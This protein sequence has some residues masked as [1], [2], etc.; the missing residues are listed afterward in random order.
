MSGE[1]EFSLRSV[2]MAA[3]VPSTLYG[4]SQG[5]VL[6]VIALSALD[7]GASSAVAALIASLL[8]TGAIVTNIPSGILATRVGENRAMLVASAVTIL[9]LL[10]CLVPVHSQPAGLLLLGLAILLL[11][12]ASSVFNLARQAYLTEAVP[13]RL[14]ARALS[15]L[16]GMSRI[17]VFLGPFLS[18]VAIHRWGLPGAYVVSLVAMVA[19]A[20]IIARIPDLEAGEQR[21]K[22]AAEVTTRV[23]LRD[24]RRVFLTLGLGIVLLCAV[25]QTRQ[26]VIPL[27][28]AH[29]GLSSA[30]SSVIY[31][32]AGG[33]DVVTFYPAGR[34]MDRQGRRWVA[35]P[36]VLLLAASFVAMTWSHG[37]VT[38]ALA[39]CVMGFGNGIGSGIVMTL[40]ADTSP[41]VGRY[42]FLG[43]WR[44]LAD[45]GS[46]V[47]PLILSAVTALAG[48][49]TGFRF[50]GVLGVAAAGA[51]WRWIP[52]DV[53]LDRTRTRGPRA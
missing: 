48:L 25:R 20:F 13:A 1:T 22:A 9:G 50:S 32:L 18:A 43:I 29:I 47:G 37:T 10:V 4:L 27:W 30:S 12:A 8:G 15:T 14:R 23:V 35:V 38:L 21:R 28:A 16:G 52:R 51:L 24:Y 39:A 40:G 33:I 11:G 31:G 3:F 46:A 6:P 5:A 26:V 45:V 41:A 42:A 7:R 2:A 36:C 49:A 53:T 34:V 19:A 17:G 44:E